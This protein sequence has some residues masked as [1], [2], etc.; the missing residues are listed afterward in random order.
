LPAILSLAVQRV[1]FEPPSF[2]FIRSVL[3]DVTEVLAFDVELAGVLPLDTDATPVLYIGTVELSYVEHVGKVSYRYVALP[4]QEE[5]MR[6]GAPVSL[7]WPG[8]KPHH[9]TRFHF[10]RQDVGYGRED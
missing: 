8:E 5:L 7:G 4:E 3:A 6:A 2:R 1:P 9:E 10:R